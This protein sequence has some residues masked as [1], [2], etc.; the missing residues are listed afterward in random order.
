MYNNQNATN[1]VHS[2]IQHGLTKCIEVDQ[3]FFRQK[4]EDNKREPSYVSTNEQVVDLF[5]K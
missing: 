1:I 4:M 5:T 3:Y 2:P